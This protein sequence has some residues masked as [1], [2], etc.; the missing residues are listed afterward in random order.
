MSKKKTVLILG[1]CILLQIALVVSF[2]AEKEGYFIDEV[3]SFSLSNRPETGFFEPSPNTWL[4]KE[5]YLTNVAVQ[6][7]T[8]FDY[9]NVYYNQ[10]QDVAPP[11]FYVL[12]HSVCSMFPRQLSHWMGIGVNLIFYIGC[13][14]LL[15]CLGTQILKDKKAGILLS[16][17]F[18]I[19]YGAIN[20]A[21]FIRMYMQATFFLL[22]HM[23]VYLRYF[24]TEE[25]SKQGYVWLG[26]TAVLGSLTQ[27]YFFIAAVFLGCWYTVKFLYEKRKNELIRY[28]L[29][30]VLSAVCAVAIFPPMI[31]HVLKSGRGVEA[32]ENFANANGYFANLKEMFQIINAQ[33]FGGLLPILA[34]LLLGVA[35]WGHKLQ[36]R[37]YTIEKKYWIPIAI[38]CVG[39][40]MT[41]TKVAPYQTDRYLMPI[42]PLVYTLVAGGAYLVLRECTTKKKAL[43]LCLLVFGALSIKQVSTTPFY[44]LFEDFNSKNVAEE[45]TDEK[46]VII[47]ENHGYWYY[48]LQALTQYEAFYW[49]KDYEDESCLEGLRD[50]LAF[51][52][53]FV[54]Y[55]TNTWSIF[56]VQNFLE[57]NFEEN[58]KLELQES[59]DSERYWIYHCEKI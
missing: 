37:E 54:L 34:V 14:I 2:A 12:L 53:N 13:M 36:K 45:Y 41:V 27:Y 25:V 49:L 8:K 46:C 59:C 22:A 55:V 23:Y 9:V 56:D 32:F 47:S 38:T 1:I 11:L 58:W 51:S 15:F 10:K 42:Y 28:Y 20:S 24:E 33:L 6:E 39:Y 35:I 50:R 7:D 19:T 43:L 18:G 44:Y 57:E 48:D 26:I 4:D 17:L 5:W 31:W 3:L 52:E 30:I 29:T 16:F 21:I 40:F